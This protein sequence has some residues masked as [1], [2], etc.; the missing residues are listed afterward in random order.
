MSRLVPWV[1][2]N[3]RAVFPLVEPPE[4]GRSLRKVIKRGTFRVT[5]DH[6]FREVILVDNA[7]LADRPDDRPGHAT[8][9]MRPGAHPHD[10]GLHAVDGGLPGVRIHH[11]NQDN[12][13]RSGRYA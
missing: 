13:L 2:P 8:G 6:A 3:P 5:L 9:Q 1:S 12:L 4:W 7:L 11:D 10:L